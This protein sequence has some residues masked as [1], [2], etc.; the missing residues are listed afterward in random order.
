MN[1]TVTV[2]DDARGEGTTFIEQTTPPLAAAVAMI[3]DDSRLPVPDLHVTF[4]AD[5]MAVS[6]REGE[7]LG[8]P[9]DHRVGTERVGGILGGKCLVSD[10]GKQAAI[11]ITAEAA[12][13]SDRMSQLLVTEMIAH[14]LGHMIYG[15]ARKAEI[16]DFPKVSLPWE[17]AGVISVIAA[18][19]WRADMFALVATE[20]ILKPTDD[21]GTPVRLTTL[22]GP[23]WAGNSL[24]G[25]LDELSPRL[26]TII[27]NYRNRRLDLDTMWQATA[28]ASEGVTI[29]VAHADAHHHATAP[30][31]EH[32]GHSGAHLLEPVWRPLLTHVRNGPGFPARGEWADDRAQLIELGR[33]GF[34]ELWR[35]LGLS[36]RPHGE[37]F[38]LTVGDP[39]R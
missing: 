11:V 15:A 17:I 27:W 24:T 2:P 22:T 36:A 28:R 33:T 23:Q 9:P 16:G 32:V 38:Y 6:A 12:N 21:T 37:A 1:V 3:L 29:F 34:T 5:V 20:A 30:V 31:L 7:R 39:V 18:E 13:P 35:R 19:E 10:N 26:E 4:A 8:L 14:E 25:A